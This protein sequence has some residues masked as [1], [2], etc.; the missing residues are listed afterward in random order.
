MGTISQKFSIRIDI[1]G[2]VTHLLDAGFLM[3]RFGHTS[4]AAILISLLV[5]KQLMYWVVI[6]DPLFSTR[7]VVIIESRGFLT[8]AA[9]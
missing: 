6:G 9:Q 8:R 5:D 3:A 2:S 4:S 7:D 1:C